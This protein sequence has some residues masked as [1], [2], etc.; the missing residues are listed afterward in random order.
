[1]T[2]R[3]SVILAA[4]LIGAG[5]VLSG[6]LS[7]AVR[8]QAPPPAPSLNAQILNTPIEG[9]RGQPITFAAT[10]TPGPNATIQSYG[11]DFGDGSTGDGQS[12][13]HTYAR[14]GIYSVRLTVTD[15]TGATTSPPST[16]AEISITTAGIPGSIT[17]AAGDGVQFYSPGVPQP[18]FVPGG[19]PPAVCRGPFCSGRSV[20]V[21]ND[22]DQ[23]ANVAYSNSG[24]GV[25]VPPGFIVQLHAG[26]AV[27]PDQYTL[28]NCAAMD[29]QVNEIGC[30]VALGSAEAS[31][32]VVAADSGSQS[33]ALS[34]NSSAGLLGPM[35]NAATGDV[36]ALTI[37]NQSKQPAT[38]DWDG[39]MLTIVVPQGFVPTVGSLQSGYQRL[40]A[41]EANC[42]PSGDQTNVIAC[43]LTAIPPLDLTLDAVQQAPAGTL[44][45]SY[46]DSSGNGSL[47][48]TNDGPDVAPGGAS[49]SVTLVQNGTTFG[50]QGVMRPDHGA[51][52]FLLTFNLSDAQ[53][54]SYLYEAD[55]TGSGNAWSANGAWLSQSDPT[56]TGW[57]SGGPGPPT[58]NSGMFSPA[59]LSLVSPPPVISAPPGQAIVTA[60]PPF[61][62]PTPG[63]APGA[64]A[65]FLPAL[66]GSGVAQP[67]VAGLAGQSVS[68]MAVT[69]IPCCG[70]GATQTYQWFFGDGSSSDPGTQQ[71]VSH[72]WNAAG[73]YTVTVVITDE[74]GVSIFA[75]T[76]VQIRASA[77]LSR[78]PDPRSAQ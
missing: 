57:W 71:A 53:G 3:L 34:Q 6:P 75:A 24:L 7:A 76:Q 27:L 45:L 42:S 49:V 43:D 67:P 32:T 50:G 40:P 19:P 36:P 44:T 74:T 2:K 9:I 63:G 23:Q 11:W 59:Q 38:A 78:P 55:L 31:I 17:L 48:I 18:V 22:S 56:Q 1:M 12:V 13:S 35:P 30:N 73:L 15:S 64:T 20:V 47:A 10:A 61:G 21:V 69:V 65:E 26:Q 51:S 72:V 5:L 41:D 60:G 39:S 68:L 58:P 46:T 54:D 14:A 66:V 62:S 8:G 28:Q 37:H 52:G 77:Q 4:A 33:V 29:G 25:A 70:P 16:Q